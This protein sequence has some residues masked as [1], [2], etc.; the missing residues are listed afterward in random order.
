MAE[1]ALGVRSTDSARCWALP[2]SFPGLIKT[3]RLSLMRSNDGLA[4]GAV[5]LYQAA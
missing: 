3:R 2:S 1:R 4:L 5:V